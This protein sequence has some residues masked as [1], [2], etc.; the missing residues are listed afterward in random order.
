MDAHTYDNLVG[1]T[2]TPTPFAINLLRDILIPGILQED[3]SSISYW[4]GKNLARTYQVS[5]DQE[6]TIFFLNAGFGELTKLSEKGNQQIW[7]LSGDFVKNR[8][9]AN[10][11]QP[12]FNLEAGFLSQQIEQAMPVVAEANFEVDSKKQIVLIKVQTE[13]N[14]SITE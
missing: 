10:P 5:L 8:F 4:A 7:Q 9:L 13:S 2:G 3:T 6:M 12:D 14:V 11:T 1:A